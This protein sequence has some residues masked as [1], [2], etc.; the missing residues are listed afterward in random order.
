MFAIYDT[1]FAH[2]LTQFATRFTAEKWGR[3]AEAVTFTD[4]AAAAFR[5]AHTFHGDTA[6]IVVA[7][8]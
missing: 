3:M 4:H 2:Y 5:I 8:A 7:V 6:F 1:R